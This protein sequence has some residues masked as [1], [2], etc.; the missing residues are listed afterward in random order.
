MK[1]LFVMILGM[2]CLLL[3]LSL[4]S[5]WAILLLVIFWTR[6]IRRSGLF[7]P[8]TKFG[9]AFFS[10]L[11]EFVYHNVHFWKAE[12]VVSMVNGGRLKFHHLNTPL[13][14]MALPWWASL[15]K[16]VYGSRQKICL[17]LFNNTELKA[18][19]LRWWLFWNIFVS[20]KRIMFLLITVDFI[21]KVP[22]KCFK[23]C[24]FGYR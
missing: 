2:R 6:K 16:I 1:L 8:H 18:K 12:T 10:G 9:L 23:Y 4:C 11:F 3:L 19:Q 22:R 20:L 5:F 7:F 13:C 15:H 24:C 17:P 14:L 21:S